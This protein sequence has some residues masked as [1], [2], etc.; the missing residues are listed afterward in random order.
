MR[1]GV[2]SALK[3]RVP[4]WFN[5]AYAGSCEPAIRGRRDLASQA[6]KVDSRPRAQPTRGSCQ[7]RPSQ[8][9]AR[10][11]TRLPGGALAGQARPVGTIVGDGYDDAMTF[12]AAELLLRRPFQGRVAVRLARFHCI[13]G[14]EQT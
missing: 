3:W 9:S 4:P 1:C 8:S 14:F 11:Q 2:G 7:S 10:L 12:F 5:P 6:S 13:G